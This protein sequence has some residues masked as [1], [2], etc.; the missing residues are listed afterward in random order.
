MPYEEW[1]VKTH[2]PKCKS[3]NWICEGD[4]QDCTVPDTEAIECWDC[5]HKWWRDPDTP[6]E[7]GYDEDE[8]TTVEEYLEHEA[9]KGRKEPR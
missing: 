7:M 6:F 8:L 3:C 5:G 9:E 2:C 4:L 1:W